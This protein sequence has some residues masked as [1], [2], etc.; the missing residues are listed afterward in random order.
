[1]SVDYM[2]ITSSE[3]DIKDFIERI[4]N[5]PDIRISE[6]EFGGYL[7]EKDDDCHCWFRLY[8]HTEDGLSSFRDEDAF[9]KNQLNT[10]LQYFQEPKFF[11]V[12]SPC[13][14]YLYWII[15]L[16][17]NIDEVLVD[18]FPGKE[19]LSGSEFVRRIKTGEKL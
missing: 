12:S 16:I 10:I 5:Y 1:M 4:P 15:E 14:E 11:L 13:S 17:A 3:Y 6:A 19:I 18:Y 9:D 8:D 7:I 2:I